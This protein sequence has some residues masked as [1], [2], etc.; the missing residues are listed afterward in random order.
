M[1][2]FDSASQRV[3]ETLRASAVNNHKILQNKNLTERNG[4]TRLFLKNPRD[5]RVAP[6]RKHLSPKLDYIYYER[7]AQIC[8]SSALRYTFKLG[9]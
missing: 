3:F 5:S 7:S 2:S 4:A 1:N 8:V 9:Q 6:L